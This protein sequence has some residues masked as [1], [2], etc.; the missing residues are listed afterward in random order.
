MRISSW[1]WA[2]LCLCACSDAAGSTPVTAGRVASVAGAPGGASPVLAG[3]AAVGG[4]GAA[5]AGSG[6]VK[7]PA[8]DTDAGS[9]DDRDAGEPVPAEPVAPAGSMLVL[10]YNVA[11]LPEGLSSSKPSVNTPLIGPLLNGYDLVLLQETWQ[12]PD[13]NPLAPL[14]GYHEILVAASD[15]P[16]KTTPAMQPFGS[17]PSRI[18]ALLSDGLNVFSRSELG[19]TQRVAWSTCVNTD[20]DCLAFK[21]FAMTPL[22]LAEGTQVHVYDL[23]MEAGESEQDDTARAGDIDQLLAFIAQQSQDVAVILGGD[24]NLNTDREPQATQFAHLLSAAALTDACTDRGCPQP[25]NIDKLLFR[26]SAQV[27]LRAE[28]WSYEDHVFVT[29]D[30]NPLSDHLPVAVRLAWSTRASE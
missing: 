20:N 8:S 28:S 13:P 3:R 9:A 21:G 2:G 18:S 19:E 30:G 14:R 5:A 29:P 24:F 15:H 7:A 11:G 17:N 23:H 22:W 16:Y 4:A 10:T 27:T 6:G 26:S 12:T 25:G 1:L